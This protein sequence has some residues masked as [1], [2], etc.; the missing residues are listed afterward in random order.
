MKILDGNALEVRRRAWLEVAVTHASHFNHQET[1]TNTDHR[2]RTINATKYG[3]LAHRDRTANL[4]REY[5]EPRTSSNRSYQP[6]V[7]VTPKTYSKVV[8]HE[9]VLVTEFFVM[10]REQS[11]AL[12]A[13]QLHF[14]R[15]FWT[16][17]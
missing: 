11:L 3:R 10:L 8:K 7:A 1:Q 17:A 2:D 4:F 6:P 15:C 12:R 9:G 14:Y 5:D 16:W 13:V